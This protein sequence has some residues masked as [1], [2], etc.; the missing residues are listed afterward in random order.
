MSSKSAS[1]RNESPEPT[2]ES[3][4]AQTTDKNQ[5]QEES[6]P[7]VYSDLAELTKARL[8]MLVLFTV[9][10]GYYI[11]QE[12]GGSFWNLL[13]VMF[14]TALVASAA[15]AINQFM[16]ADADAQM[17]RTKTR[18]LPQGRVNPAE[19]VVLSCVAAIVGTIYLCIFTGFLSAIIALV[20]LLSYV[21]IYT[22]LKRYSSLNTLVGAIPGALPPLIGWAAARDSIDLVALALFGILFVWQLPHFLAIAWIYRD[23]Y[24]QGGFQMLTNDDP[25]GLDTSFKSL[26]YAA[27]LLPISILPWYFGASGMIYLVVAV[28]LGLVYA[29]AALKFRLD[30]SNQTARVLFIAS[31]FYLPLLLGALVFDKI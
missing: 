5:E 15:S 9:A 7:T 30:V 24:R 19:V 20:T 31:I 22:P 21:L 26:L 23:D 13:H 10:V 14:G 4:A 25:E 1:F 28:V 11:G 2:P 8:T 16:E 12:P 29:F 27:T 17:R 6:R 3:S 18:P